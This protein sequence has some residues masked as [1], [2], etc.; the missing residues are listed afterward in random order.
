MRTAY[1]NTLY[2]LAKSDKRVYAL[3]SDNG[4][5]VYDKYRK[6]LPEQ[7]LN[8]G[9][10]EA[11]MIGM[12]AGMASCGKIPFAY[13]IGAFLAYR[14]F[15]FIRND[16][17][18]QNQNVKIVGTGAGEIYSALGPTHH[19]TEDLG[20]LR[21]VPNLTIICP[22]SPTE[23]KKATK[24]A[25]EHE[26]AVYLRLGTNRES[27]I[28][29]ED[30][31]FRIGKAVTLKEGED[32]T[33]VGTGSILKDIVDVA[34]N[35]NTE[36]IS[37]RVINMH[38]IKPIDKNAII[39]AVDETGKIVTVEDHNIIGG[40]GSA[41]AEV[42][43]E[44]GREVQFKRLGLYNFSKGY[45]NYIEIKHGNGIGMNSICKCVKEMVWS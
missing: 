40:I 2:E 29:D 33:L 8:L 30:Y 32:I 45:G 42:I 5:I 3:I 27:E 26:G 25:Y 44:Y 6:D 21:A 20:G 11:N 36:G 14:A 17:C 15:E 31:E 12:A 24:A 19:S 43:A 41:V 38:T 37:V 18:L 9:I 1:L 10:S 22:A 39:K 13:T 28:Y 35:L 16:V 23:V 7:Y 34:D 4:A